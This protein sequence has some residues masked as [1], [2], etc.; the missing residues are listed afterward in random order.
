MQIVGSARDLAAA[1]RERLSSLK[2]QA[3]EA[4]RVS[5]LWEDLLTY[6][7]RGWP[8]HVLAQLNKAAPLLMNLRSDG[9]PAIPAIEDAYRAARREGDALLKGY[10]AIL[11]EACQSAQL[12][13]DG[14]SRHPR[15]S[16]RERFFILEVDEQRKVAR[17]SDREGKLSDFPAD[18]GAVVQAVQRAEKR[19]FGRPFDGGKL[20]KLLRRQYLAILRKSKQP[21]G[22]AIP[23]RHI[24][25]RLGRNLK[26]FRTDEFLVDISRLLERGPLE[27]D[28][29]RLDLQQTKDTEQGMLL[30]GRAGLGYVGFVVFRKE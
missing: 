19:V 16:F 29:C 25:R 28:G 17:L 2:A 14:D 15:Y 18:V 1:A 20:L 9:H 22:S 7:E 6:L 24:T 4:A 10:P 5:R 12:P 3:E 13:L 21:D 27:L 30:L 23:I 11:F 26:G 8:L